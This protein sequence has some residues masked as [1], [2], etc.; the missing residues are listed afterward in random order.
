MLELMEQKLQTQD[1]IDEEIRLSKLTKTYKTVHC[2]VDCKNF[3]FKKG[4][5]KTI[6]D[7]FGKE[8]YIIDPDAKAR[9]VLGLI[10][11]E[12]REEDRLFNWKAHNG[13]YSGV[14]VGFFSLLERARRMKTLNRKCFY[15]EGMD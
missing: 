5:A 12:D 14:V 1:A 15:F 10:Q 7:K 13:S 11:Y 9:C 6:T 8:K 3:K 4:W 2:C